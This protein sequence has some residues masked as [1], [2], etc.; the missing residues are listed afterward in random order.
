MPILVPVETL[1]FNYGYRCISDYN[2]D[3][4][5]LDVWDCQFLQ[6]DIAIEVNCGNI[7]FH[8]VLINECN[9][10]QSIWI[11]V[12]TGDFIAEN[13]TIDADEQ[14]GSISG[15]IYLTNC[16]QT[17]SDGVWS[18]FCR[19]QHQCL[20]SSIYAHLSDRRPRQL[21]PRSRQ[22][23]SQYWHHQHQPRSIGRTQD[24]DHLRAPGRRLA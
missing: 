18:L 22:P 16:L 7:A 12:T 5:Q 17:A 6:V 10:D 14:L 1:W 2:G 11:D 13:M 3:N 23:L 9:A 21:L 19:H 8:N 20:H 4:L 15:N 24:H